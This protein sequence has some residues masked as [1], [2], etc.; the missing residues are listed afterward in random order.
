MKYWNDEIRQASLALLVSGLAF[1]MNAQ[2]ISGEESA[3]ALTASV[4]LPLVSAEPLR[5]ML[6]NQ[7]M[8]VAGQEFFRNF[9]A[10]WRDLPVSQRYSVSIHERPSVRQGTRIWVAFNRETMFQAFLPP[11][12]DQILALSEQAVAMVS[13]SIIDTDLN[14]AMYR[15]ADLAADEI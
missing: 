5:G 9:A 2:A 3:G 8:T 12:R 13:A 14:R 10:G 11:G 4:S 7:T 15:D 1:S 6:V